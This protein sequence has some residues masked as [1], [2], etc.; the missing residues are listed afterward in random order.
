MGQATG[1]LARAYKREGSQKFLHFANSDFSWKWSH[2][3][4]VSHF[5]SCKTFLSIQEQTAAEKWVKSYIIYL[6][7][8]VIPLNLIG[9]FTN[10]FRELGNFCCVFRKRLDA[11]R[12]N[13]EIIQK[14]IWCKFEG[15][16][17]KKLLLLCWLYYVVHNMILEELISFI[18]LPPLQIY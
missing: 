5:G 8:Y 7:Y 11:Y 17:R 9:H 14:R 4:R 6:I 3:S 16:L 10:L 2:D 1:A 12:V 13:L 18:F 15:W